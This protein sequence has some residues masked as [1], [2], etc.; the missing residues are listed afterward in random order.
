MASTFFGVEIA[1]RGLMAQSAAENVVSNNIVNAN[2]PGYTRQVAD[3]VTTEPFPYPAANRENVAG[4]LGTGVVVNMIDSARDTMLNSRINENN[5]QLA[6]NTT[7][8]QGLSQIESLFNEPSTPSIGDA[9]NN[10][11]GGLNDV[12]NNPDNIG[13]RNNLV[14]LATT[15]TGSF[16]T[17]N[18][19]LDNMTTDLNNRV[20][21]DVQS[22]NNISSEI[23]NV[24]NEIFK[25]QNMG[26][27]TNDLLDKRQNLMNDLSKLTNF[28]ATDMKN[29]YM[30]IEI[31]GHTQ[32]GVNYT[33]QM[34]S[35]PDPANNN[36]TKAV[37]ADDGSDA[38]ISGGDLSG[39]ASLR[40]TYIPEYRSSLDSMAQSL[41]TSM[42]SLQ[43]A[44][45]GIN[46][47]APTGINFFN[48]TDSSDI[49]VNPAIASD[50]TQIAAAAAANSP[51]DGTNALAMADLGNAAI[52]D[53]NTMTMGEHYATLVSKVG[54]DSLTAQNN[55]S[56]YTSLSGNLSSQLQSE[57]GVSLD[58][59]MTNLI[60][61]QHA[62]EACSK[63]MVVQD[64]M[65]Q[66]IIGM[67]TQ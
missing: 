34:K 64:Q 27:T 49:T 21:T 51:G 26:Y 61:Y 10:F 67:I 63:V 25:A 14:N 16:Q 3:M 2:T 37:F 48:G 30:K 62:Y 45:Y 33:V 35:V 54:S 38:V 20:T 44:G 22:I 56:I 65:L 5:S 60:K 52:M 50:V 18:N 23:N 41:M 36:N 32:V 6:S 31:N 66:T 29:G 15:L 43:S 12:A 42:N 9:L 55:D 59:E 4:Q 17:M 11:L 19:N 57:S 47:A 40:D 24:N 7:V 13:V 1:S 53:G 46:G 39:I 8:S 28:Q 58:E